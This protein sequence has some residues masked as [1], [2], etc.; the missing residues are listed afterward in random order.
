MTLEKYAEEQCGA[1]PEPMQWVKDATASR[2]LYDD[3][4]SGSV[5]G[6][7]LAM[8]VH[9]QKA[10]KV[11]ELGTFTGYAT[12]WMA[13][14]LSDDGRI[15]TV[16]SNLKYLTIAR[17]AFQR[18]PWQNRIQSEYSDA[19]TWIQKSEELFDL[20]Y[21]DA[22]K[23]RYPHYFEWCDA[24][25]ATG[26]LLIADNTWWKGQ[27]VATSKDAKG[28]ALSEFNKVLMCHP[29]YEKV[30]LPIRDGLIVARKLA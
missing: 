15:I 6:R 16:D 30:F 17:Q 23:R 14:A 13:S 4:I 2:L 22:D 19:L 3:M 27:A 8:L 21:L 28:R 1:D 11:L 26:G 5:T 12:L 7:L 29:R 18:S 9:L 25:L 24:K 10:K 20:I